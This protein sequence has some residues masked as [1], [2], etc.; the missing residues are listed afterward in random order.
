MPHL[1]A[2]FAHGDGTGFC[3]GPRAPED[4]KPSR[5]EGDVIKDSG[6]L[7]LHG[8]QDAGQTSL[9]LQFGFSQVKAGKNVVLIMRGNA[10]SSQQPAT[11]EVVPISACSKCKQPI[12]TGENNN[13]WSR[14]NIKY[15]RSSAELQHFLCSVHLVDKET[16]V[17]L[18]DGFES[19]F[20]DQSH[21]GN[22]YQTLAFMLE[23][24]TFM[25][26]TT[27]YGA[28]VVTGSTDSVLLRDRRRLRR[29]CR[30]LEIVPDVEEPDVFIL[31]EEMENAA[32]VSEC[33]TGIQVL[34]EFR[35]Q[36]DDTSGTFQL[37][38]VQ[39]RSR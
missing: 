27:G 10:G 22:V 31:R 18:V 13:V 21:M 28:V 2:F 29:W 37:L 34:F 3:A 38:H 33:A 14:I 36:T 30:F 9:L 32:V 23:A 26:T 8:P 6:V 17:L 20:M 15:L 39:Q 24:Q 11:S 19:F 4:T 5:H 12:Q 1:E 7:F 25:K 35:T 16:S